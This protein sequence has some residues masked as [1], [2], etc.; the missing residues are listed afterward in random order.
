MAT[1]PAES[2]EW[3]Q[4]AR[5]LQSPASPRQLILMFHGVG[6]NADSMA[7]AGH[8][9]A[10]AF[11]Q[12]MV[13]AVQGPFL[14]GNPGGHQWFSVAGIT[15]DNRQARVDQAMG[16]FAA[17]IRYWQDRA[18][19]DTQATALVGFSQG[20]IMALESTKLEQAL[21][22][23][24]V[25]MGGRFANLPVNGAYAGSIHFLH[26]KEDGVIP[27]QNTVMAAHALRDLGV[28]MTAEVLPFV[29]HEIHPDFV[30]L[31]VGKLSNHLSHRVWQ[32]AMVPDQP[33]A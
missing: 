13:V 9:L 11:D 18:A 32:A 28:D 10:T 16:L 6:S 8:A 30:T 5:I 4:N 23:R 33:P 2:I 15:E 17:C 31:M 24:V 29:G 12:A 1:T 3:A 27:Y 22:S 21:A 25:A 7:S 20:A 14:T 19:L 26:G